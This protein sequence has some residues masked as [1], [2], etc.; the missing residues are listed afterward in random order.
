[1]AANCLVVPRAIV[2]LAGITVIKTRVA[3]VTVRVVEP[4]IH[5][6][7]AVIV[8][9]PSPFEV[10]FPFDM[11]T[12]PMVATDLFK[13]LQLTDLVMSIVLLSE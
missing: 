1:M 6:H 10:A 11:T 12:L 8:V 3:G 2:G 7:L 9:A 13:E 5:P 4:A